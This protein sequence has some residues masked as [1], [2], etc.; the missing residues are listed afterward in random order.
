MDFPWL[1]LPIVVAAQAPLIGL[2]FSKRKTA[3][4]RWEEM[5][6]TTDPLI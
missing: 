5:D 4:E 6:R 1:L 2:L 3:Y